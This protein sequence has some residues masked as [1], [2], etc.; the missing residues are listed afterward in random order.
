MRARETGVR[1]PCEICKTP[2]MFQF[3]IVG[4]KGGHIRWADVCVHCGE[5]PALTAKLKQEAKAA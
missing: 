2:T 3:E 5:Q 4:P 1:K